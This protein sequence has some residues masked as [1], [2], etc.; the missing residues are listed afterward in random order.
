MINLLKP[1]PK[2]SKQATKKARAIYNYRLS[3]ACMCVECAFSILASRF[4]FLL[5][6][7]MLS[8]SMAT[9][10]VQAACVLHNFLVKDSDPFMQQM[11]AKA[12]AALQEAR[13][14]NVSGLPGVP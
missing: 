8:P 7:M 1:Y 6:C 13:S 12:Q 5:R 9:S 14:Q 10:C 3:C 2:R 4:R 11:K